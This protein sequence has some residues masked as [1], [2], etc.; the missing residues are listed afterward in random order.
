MF[1]LRLKRGKENDKKLGGAQSTLTC[2]GYGH[3]GSQVSVM[4]E[5]MG[6]KVIYFDTD[7]KLPLG[8]PVSSNTL[9]ELLEKSDFVT[10]HVPETP[11]TQN[12][13]AS[14]QLRRMKKVSFLLN[15]SR[16]AVV[17]IDDLVQALKEERLA[18][19]ALDVFPVEPAS[20][21]E[22][23][24]SPLQ[25]L[26]NVILTPHIGGSTE[27]AQ[28]A[29]G[30][31]VA[32]SFRKFL[33]SGSTAGAFNFTQVELP[34]TTGTHRILSV[35][36]N[37]PGVMGEVNSLVSKHGANILAQQLSTNAKI[38]YLVMDVEKAEAQALG[39]DIG[40]LSRSIK[41]RIVI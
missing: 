30:L 36:R 4:A 7:K 2:V 18:G 23:F 32:E 3:I 26:K 5:A 24:V 10:L 34:P 19:C 25:G 6:L 8:N 38:G 12:M 16:G 20:N 27:E 41:T 40:A 21:K 1:S 22:R 11:Q 39:A 31:E 9:F 14:A 28:Y 37:E 15:L 17:V 33:S 29:I 13:I 35:R